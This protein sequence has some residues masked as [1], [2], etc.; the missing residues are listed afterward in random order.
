MTK[1]AGRFTTVR[2]TK[3]AGRFTTSSS[4]IRRIFPHARGLVERPDVTR[5]ARLHGGSRK[6][7]FVAA[8][9]RRLPR[10]IL[11]DHPRCERRGDDVGVFSLRFR[12]RQDRLFAA[13][14]KRSD[15]AAQVMPTVDPPR[16]LE[17]MIAGAAL[18]SALVD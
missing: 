3:R 12:E 2:L 13:P 14:R 10:K 16:A 8:P 11:A 9:T 6:L 7:T 15:S 4:F 5:V 1:P 17:T 18:T